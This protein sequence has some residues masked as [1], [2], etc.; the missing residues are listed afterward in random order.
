MNFD[1]NVCFFQQ[2]ITYISQKENI[3]VLRGEI[4]EWQCVA[5]QADETGAET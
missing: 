1:E 2:K 3:F 5:R 4:L